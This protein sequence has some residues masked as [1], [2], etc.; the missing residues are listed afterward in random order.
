MHSLN[1]TTSLHAMSHY[2]LARFDN[3][4]G[5]VDPLERR[6]ASSLMKGEYKDSLKLNNA[7]LSNGLFS[8]TL[9]GSSLGRGL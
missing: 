4:R 9:S 2:K 6:V 5:S 3:Q 1:S 7:T 8:S